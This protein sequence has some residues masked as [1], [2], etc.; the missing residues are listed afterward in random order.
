MIEN[1]KGIKKAL[2]MPHLSL[3]KSLMPSSLQLMS[4][5]LLFSH[6]NNWR[7]YAINLNLVA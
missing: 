4:F 5:H 3:L 1:K 6:I 2:E 7:K